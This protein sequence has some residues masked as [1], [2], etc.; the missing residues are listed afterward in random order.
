MLQPVQTQTCAHFPPKAL[1]AS[2]LSDTSS[3]HLS[4]FPCTS[5]DHI[6]I[7]VVNLP[8]HPHPPSL[9]PYLPS[10]SHLQ[11]PHFASGFQ[12][13][14]LLWPHPDSP[15]VSVS[16]P[17]CLWSLFL[18]ADFALYRQHGL[19]WPPHP[20][21]H[22]WSC[23]SIFPLSSLNIAFRFP[24]GA[25]LGL[26]P[27]SFL[28]P[29]SLMRFTPTPLPHPSC[30]IR[31]LA[32][33]H[34]LVL[35]GL[36]QHSCSSAFSFSSSSGGPLPH[37]PQALPWVYNPLPLSQRCPCL[38]FSSLESSSWPVSLPSNWPQFFVLIGTF[39]LP[40]VS[41]HLGWPPHPWSPSWDAM[42]MNPEPWLLSHHPSKLKEAPSSFLSPN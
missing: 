19:L 29:F 36:C 13:V 39:T 21:V 22:R 23:S 5:H 37:L 3:H 31:S 34:C 32:C 18:W 24:L 1:R 16:L 2:F 38:Q 7:K 6:V 15:F 20:P 35:P 42:P 26:L 4:S 40:I 30:E 25:R 41:L 27:T 9:I 12:G 8:T 14:S 10:L 11:E 33:I 17:P 28:S